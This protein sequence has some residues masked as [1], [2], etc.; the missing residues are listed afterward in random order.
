MK[1]D[2]MVEFYDK[3]GYVPSKEQD[4]TIC[5]KCGSENIEEMNVPC[6]CC[7]ALEDSCW[8]APRCKDCG[9]VGIGNSNGGLWFKW[10]WK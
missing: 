6:M 5:P 10:W 2:D 3:K 1:W 7:R 8:S 9:L 4:K